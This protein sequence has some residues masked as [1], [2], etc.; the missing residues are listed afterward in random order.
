MIANLAE[1]LESLA[2]REAKIGKDDIELF[3][4]Q[5][6]DGRRYPFDMTDT[7]RHPGFRQQ[8]LYQ[9]GISLIILDKQ[10]SDQLSRG[11]ITGISGLSFH[12]PVSDLFIRLRNARP[13]ERELHHGKPEVLDRPDDLDEL[14]QPDWLGYPAVGAQFVASLDVPGSLG[15]GED[16]HR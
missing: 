13:F 3:F 6:F 11:R 12:I 9:I 4:I 5:A 14:F 16:H 10:G 8:L 1:R 15:S 7:N 2:V